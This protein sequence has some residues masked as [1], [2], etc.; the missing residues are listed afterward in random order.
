M[1]EYRTNSSVEYAKVLNE[2]DYELAFVSYF[3]DAANQHVILTH[4]FLGDWI[5]PT[6]TRVRLKHFFQT[7]LAHF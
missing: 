4:A 2:L 1:N 6:S 3:D 7:I 5:T